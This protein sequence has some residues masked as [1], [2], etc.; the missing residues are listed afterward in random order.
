MNIGNL[1]KFLKPSL[2][3]ILLFI[4]LFILFQILDMWYGLGGGIGFPLKFWALGLAFL[5]GFFYPIYLI[6]DALF[7]YFL[8]ALFF[9]SKVSKIIVILILLITFTVVDKPLR[10]YCISKECDEKKITE[11]MEECENLGME[12]VEGTGDIIGTCK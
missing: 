9:H 4:F 10:S 8:S 12:W 6:I 1:S 11:I 5:G 2:K 3:N 7:F